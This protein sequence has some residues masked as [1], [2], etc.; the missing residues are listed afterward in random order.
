MWVCYPNYYLKVRLYFKSTNLCAWLCML[1]GKWHFSHLKRSY[2]DLPSI[3]KYHV[4]KLIASVR[5]LNGFVG[6]EK[7]VSTFWQP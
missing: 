1:M 2:T 6:L 3:K 7:D 4:V 5:N